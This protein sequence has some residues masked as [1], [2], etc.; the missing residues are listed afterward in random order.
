MPSLEGG[1]VVMTPQKTGKT[2]Q[3]RVALLSL[4]VLKTYLS[5]LK[6]HICSSYSIFPLPF[7]SLLS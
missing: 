4:F 2:P 6:K 5:F 7:F 3:T 1:G